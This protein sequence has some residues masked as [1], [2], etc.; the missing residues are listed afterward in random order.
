MDNRAVIKDAYKEDAKKVRIPYFMRVRLSGLDGTIVLDPVNKGLLNRG[1]RLNR[2]SAD[3]NFDTTE[4]RAVA[5][6]VSD[7]NLI[8]ETQSL[9][10]R[11][12]AFISSK[13]GNDDLDDEARFN[14]CVKILTEELDETYDYLRRSDIEDYVRRVLACQN[15]KTLE[16]ISRDLPSAYS[17]LKDNIDSLSLNY[18]IDNMESLI[19]SEEIVCDTTTLNAYFTFPEKM[20]TGY[21][22]PSRFKRSLYTKVGKMNDFETNVM[23]RIDGLDNVLW[24]HRIV[25]KNN[26]EFCLRGYLHHYPDFIV[27]TVTGKTLL[28]ETKGDFNDGT[29]SK[30][31]LRLGKMWDS[32]AGSGYKY[33][34]V[35]ESDKPMLDGAITI[36]ELMGLIKRL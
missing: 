21:V 18:R 22:T 4:S 12:M 20:D 2:M 30:L 8:A 24:W 3:V 7:N 25:D 34:M 10:P 15:R 13:F 14:R 17:T 36:D 16:S 5:M 11:Q 6:D 31:K 23:L 29:D 19:D 1:M 26:S 33:Y 35:F 27:R 9:N 32:L 28:V